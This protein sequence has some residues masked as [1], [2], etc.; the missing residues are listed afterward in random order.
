MRLRREI[1]RRLEQATCDKT[2]LQALTRRW[3]TS[4]KEAEK[5]LK[6]PPKGREKPTAQKKKR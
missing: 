5:A 3:Y 1:R 4:F 2:G 6:A